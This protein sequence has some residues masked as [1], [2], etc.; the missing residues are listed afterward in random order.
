MLNAVGM[1]DVAQ[2]ECVAWE[3]RRG[4]NTEPFGTSTEGMGRSG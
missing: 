3:D 2:A 1:D 4:W